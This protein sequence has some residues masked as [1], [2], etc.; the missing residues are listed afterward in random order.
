M[1]EEKDDKFL[2]Q[3]KILLPIITIL[4]LGVSGYFYYTENQ[5]QTAVKA[6]IQKS[7]SLITQGS[8]EDANN[9][10]KEA[11]N[12]KNTEEVKTIL[13]LTNDLIES[14]K[15][16]QN[17][18]KLI[19]EENY[20]SALDS[21]KKVKDADTKNF[22]AAQ[23]YI[24]QATD[25]LTLQTLAEA[26]KLYATGDYKKAYQ[27]LM[28]V[29]GLSP[30]LEEAKQLE[31]TYEKAKQRQEEQER[32][33]AERKVRE[34]ARQKMNKYEVGIGAVAIAVGEVKKTSQVNANY[35]SYYYVNDPQND[36]FLWLWINA[37]NM[38]TKTVHVNPNDF[39][40]TSPDGYTAN[41]DKTSF[42]TKYLDATNV[43]PNS[44]VSGWLIFLVPK[45]DK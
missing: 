22:T 5:K 36:Q 16:F 30:T 15:E 41:Y 43:P 23:N 42:Y 4:I 13:T 1:A 44:Y 27:A 32:L 24:K 10:A 8:Y 25:S 11:A 35:G 3:A 9:I 20:K 31:K 45:A 21:F 26:K 18:V 19:Q 40:V 38:G 34:E 2:I 29:Q 17:A 12:I 37:A 7:K 6:L 33:E 39:T 28:Q 14:D